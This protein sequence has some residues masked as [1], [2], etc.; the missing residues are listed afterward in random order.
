VRQLAKR[1][2]GFRCVKCGAV[3]GLEV[4]HIQPV[5]TAPELSYELS[6]LQTLCGSCHSKKTI[7]EIGI[8]DSPAHAE[9]RK[10]DVLINEL[11]RS[12][13]EN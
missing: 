7:F 12:N 11:S 13:L 2:D 10:F 8:A 3:V 9:R 5:R 6:N 1:R 4:D